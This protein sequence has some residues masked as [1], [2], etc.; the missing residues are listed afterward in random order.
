MRVTG[1]CHRRGDGPEGT[2][3]V[4][5]SPPGGPCLLTPH[6]R[7]EEQRDE[8]LQLCP[9]HCRKDRP[10]LVVRVHPVPRP[11]LVR[12]AEGEGWIGRGREEILPD[13]PAEH[14]A[15]KSQRSLRLCWSAAS[16]D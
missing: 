15:D 10:D 5:V 6:G 3:R 9:G 2:V 16:Q 1:L 13:A 4:K 7:V 14:G 12:E 8:V 11:R